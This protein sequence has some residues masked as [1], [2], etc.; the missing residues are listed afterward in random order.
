MFEDCRKK[1]DRR[2]KVE[3]FIKTSFASAGHFLLDISIPQPHL[4]LSE[5]L[6]K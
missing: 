4:H 2:Q 5:S 6:D 1:V 3:F